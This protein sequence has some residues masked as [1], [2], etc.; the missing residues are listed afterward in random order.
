[1][2]VLVKPNGAF[3]AAYMK[4]IAPFRLLIVYPAIIREVEREWPARL[5]QLRSAG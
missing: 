3:G 2:A 5:E 4:A 1:M